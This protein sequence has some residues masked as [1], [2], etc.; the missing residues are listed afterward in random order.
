VVGGA[1][2]ETDARAAHCW[3]DVDKVSGD[4]AA[5]AWKRLARWRQAS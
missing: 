4:P 5:T 1:L 2:T 3:F